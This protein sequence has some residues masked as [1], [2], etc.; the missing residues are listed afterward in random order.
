MSDL[1]FKRISV[2]T[3]VK[4]NADENGKEVDRKLYLGMIGFDCI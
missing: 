4:L 2:G 3:N 1:K